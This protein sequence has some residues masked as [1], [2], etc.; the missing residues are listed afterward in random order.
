[1]NSALHYELTGRVIGL[2]MRV[3]SRL[4]PGFLETVYRR[5]LLW[6]LQRAGIRAEGEK[7]IRVLYEGI[8]VGDFVT[9]ITVEGTIIVELNAVARLLHIHEVQTVN[10][11][12]ATGLDIALLLNFGAESL[13]FQ[14]KY[15]LPP[16]HPRRSSSPRP[17]TPVN[18]VNPV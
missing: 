3:H 15:R 8:P 13:E 16:M 5:A 9:D 1:M 18:P 7:R 14:R 11:L 12:S 6:E 17:S 10:Y 2:A 4:G